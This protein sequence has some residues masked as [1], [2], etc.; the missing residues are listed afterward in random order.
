MERI[1]VIGS[2]R[3]GCGAEVGERNGAGR[4][5]RGV[6][7]TVAVKDGSSQRFGRGEC[8]GTE[9]YGTE[10]LLY[11]NSVAVRSSVNVCGMG[12][13]FGT[14]FGNGSEFS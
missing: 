12:F 8:F 10:K 14:D 7:W 1:S 11:N 4:L 13:G 5:H 3:S 2:V 6:R 9:R